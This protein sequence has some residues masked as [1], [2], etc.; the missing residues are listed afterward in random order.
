MADDKLKKRIVRCVSILTTIWSKKGFN[1]NM[2]AQTYGCSTRMI[3]ADIALLRSI[4]FPIKYEKG[5]YTLTVRDLKIP[6]LPLNEEQILALFIASQL[7]VLTPLERKADEALQKMLSVLSEEAIAFLRNLTDRVYIAPGGDLGDSKILFDVYRAVSECQSIHIQYQAFST[8]QEESWDLD[9]CGIY[10][11]DRDRSYLVGHTYENP[12]KYR[13]FKLCRI[14]DLKFRKMQFTYPADFSIRKEMAKG[15]WGGEQEYEVVIRFCPEVA[16]LV[17]EREPAERIEMKP[18]GSVLVR[19]TVRNL[20]E[21][22]Y[23]ILRYGSKAE[24]LQPEALREKVKQELAEW[25]QRY[26]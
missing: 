26:A 20:D 21:A 18:G 9:P 23:D 8:Q 11:K 13:R 25:A 4:G 7:L 15:F 16:Q 2:L 17:C 19:K 1:R 12:R 6:L 22:F 24:V 5:G 14:T 3:A 10:I